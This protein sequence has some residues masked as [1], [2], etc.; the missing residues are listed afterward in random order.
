MALANS[1]IVQYVIQYLQHLIY[2][3]AYLPIHSLCTYITAT[4][5]MEVRVDMCTVLDRPIHPMEHR[6]GPAHAH[7]ADAH[8]S[9]PDVW[10]ESAKGSDYEVLI[11]SSRSQYVNRKFNRFH[12]KCNANNS[13]I[14][15]MCFYKGMQ[16]CSQNF[17]TGL[18]CSIFKWNLMGFAYILLYTKF[19]QRQFLN[20]NRSMPVTWV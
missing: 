8:L 3:G 11:L 6:M 19:L 5:T 12:L 15:P 18:L 4:D 7:D 16:A 20:G 17:F 1:G 10:M 9:W 2:L 14:V 13:I